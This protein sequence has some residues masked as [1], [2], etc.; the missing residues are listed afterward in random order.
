MV[1]N[2]NSDI[3][4]EKGLIKVPIHEIVPSA[5]TEIQHGYLVMLPRSSEIAAL[6]SS[7]AIYAGFVST[8]TIQ[9]VTSPDNPWRRIEQWSWIVQGFKVALSPNCAVWPLPV[10]CTKLERLNL[11]AIQTID[12]SFDVYFCHHGSVV[13][14]FQFRHDVFVLVHF[15]SLDEYKT[16]L[17]EVIA[18]R[19]ASLPNYSPSEERQAELANYLWLSRVYDNDAADEVL[20]NLWDKEKDSHENMK[21]WIYAMSCFDLQILLQEISHRNRGELADQPIIPLIPPYEIESVASF[22]FEMTVPHQ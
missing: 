4:P 15:D 19:L 6:Y 22:I 1:Y 17:A 2:K 12:P 5:G 13:R 11:L 8:A 7:S 18:N 21:E 14:Q 16:G 20:L 3:P 9:Q 10:G